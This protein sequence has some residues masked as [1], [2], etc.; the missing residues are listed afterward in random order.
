LTGNEGNPEKGQD[1]TKANVLKTEDSGSEPC[2]SSKQHLLRVTARWS[3][4][5]LSSMSDASLVW[6]QAPTEA[7]PIGPMVRKVNM[8]L[9]L[10]LGALW[11]LVLL[12]NGLV[13]L[14]AC[15]RAR[16]VSQDYARLQGLLIQRIEAATLDSARGLGR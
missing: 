6:S 3:C 2:Q 15:L 12:G 14:V 1:A 4:P 16:T 10:G 11:C 7:G 8:Y 5:V 13:T 9:M